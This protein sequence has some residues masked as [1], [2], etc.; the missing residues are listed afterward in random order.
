VQADGLAIGRQADRSTNASP[1]WTAG[2]NGLRPFAW[3][4]SCLT[5]GAVQ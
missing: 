1:D 2:G 5:L 4:T 3:N